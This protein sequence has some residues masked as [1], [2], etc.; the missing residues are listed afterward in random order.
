MKTAN[1]VEFGDFQTPLELARE[2][3][4][5]LQRLE[6][7]PHIVVEPTCGLGG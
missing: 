7:Q 2:V 4:D 5:L 6:I 1:K 3:C